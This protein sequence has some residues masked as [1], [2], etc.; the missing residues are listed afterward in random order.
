MLS[1]ALPGLALSLSAAV[2]CKVLASK[3]NNDDQTMETND[4]ESRMADEPKSSRMKQWASAL[5][6]VLGDLAVG[7]A[8]GA[9]SS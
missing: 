8:G 7:F 6:D 4:E 3:L 1:S 2:I 5:C 9:V